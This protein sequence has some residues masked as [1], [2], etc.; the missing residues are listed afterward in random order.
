MNKPFKNII[1][2]FI[3]EN[4]HKVFWSYSF[5][6]LNSSKILP[7]LPTHPTSYSPSLILKNLSSPLCIIWVWGRPWVVLDPPGVMHTIEESR[8]FL[9]C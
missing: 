6:F 7:H 8:F 4:P 9:S 1:L 3:F 2:F 5:P